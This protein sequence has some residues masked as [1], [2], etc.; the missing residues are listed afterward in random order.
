MGLFI[1][2][3]HYLVLSFWNMEPFINKPVTYNLGGHLKEN[4]EIQ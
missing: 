3:K 1:L 2:I 4:A